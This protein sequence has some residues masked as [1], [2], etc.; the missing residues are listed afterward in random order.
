MG[1]YLNSGSQDL[2]PMALALHM[3]NTGASDPLDDADQ[4]YVTVFFERKLANWAPSWGSPVF[5]EA[6]RGLLV[7]VLAETKERAAVKA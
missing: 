6:V 7:A 3:S 1:H 4:A 2:L 5:D